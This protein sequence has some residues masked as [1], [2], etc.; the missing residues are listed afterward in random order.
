MNLPK[1]TPKTKR[2]MTNDIAH[3]NFKQTNHIDNLNRINVMYF[4]M[5]LAN[6]CF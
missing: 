6:F 3:Q 5:A 4:Q 1:V 2:I